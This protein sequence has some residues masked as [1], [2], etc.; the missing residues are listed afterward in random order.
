[1]SNYN[2]FVFYGSWMETLQG[3]Q[4]EF[5][6]SYAKE[7]LYNLVLAATTGK[8]ETDKKS[9]VGFI[10]GCCMPLIESAR[11]R[12]EVA[13]ENGAKGGRPKTVDKDKI[14]ELKITGKYTNEQIARQLNCSTSSVRKVW[15]DYRKELD[16]IVAQKAKNPYIETDNKSITNLVTNS[17]T[18]NNNNNTVNNKDSYFLGFTQ[19]KEAQ[20]ISSLA[21]EEIAA[22]ENRFDEDGYDIETETWLADGRDG[23][24][25]DLAARGFSSEEIEYVLTQI[26]DY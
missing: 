2:N 20:Q 22:L 4:E 26:L 24:A 12:Y 21:I 17:I 9:I 10:N 7:A 16:T 13:R 5:G 1:M 11:T 15:T 8:I 3:F 14:I 18:N 25:N 19:R 23:A 6:D